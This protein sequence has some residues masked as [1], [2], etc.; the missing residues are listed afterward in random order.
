MMIPI[1]AT[2]IRAC[3]VAMEV[4]YLRRYKVNPTRN[5]DKSSASLWDFANAIEPIGMILGF[6]NIGRIQTGRSLISATGIVLLVLG[7]LIRWAAIY[8]L[9][10]YF[11]SKVVIQNDHRLIRTGLYKHMRHPAYTGAL[12]AHL[13]LGLSFSN[14][15]SLAL[16]SVPFLVAA[17]YRMQVEETALR[18]ALGQEYADYSTKTKRL[19]PKVY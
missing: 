3:W 14:W 19:I 6:T 17:L 8:S 1:L 7:I 10:K 4:P 2:I 12:I 13:G 9:G 15:F 16:S 5:W 11:T 18:E